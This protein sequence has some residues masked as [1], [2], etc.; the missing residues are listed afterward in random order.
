[1]I[2]V[3]LIGAAGKMGR[4]VIEEANNYDDMRYQFYCS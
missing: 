4:A 2:K 3:C 1:M